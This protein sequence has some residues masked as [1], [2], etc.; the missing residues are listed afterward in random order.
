[1]SIDDALR[2]AFANW[3]AEHWKARLDDVIS[4][5]PG[6]GTRRF[7]R[8]LVSGGDAPASSVIARVDAE[9]DPSK[10]ARGVAP[11]PPLEPIRRLLNEAEIPV[12]RRFAALPEVGA[13]LLEDVGDTTLEGIAIDPATPPERRRALYA[14]AC[15]II[16]RMQ[17]LDEPTPKP[18]P[19]IEAFERTLDAALFESKA[20]RVV[21]WALPYWLPRKPTDR[22]ARIVRDFYQH[23]ARVCEGAPRRLS[24]RDFKAANVHVLPGDRLVLIDLQGAFM[25]P[26]EYDLVC[27]LRDSHV[28]LPWEEVEALL[29]ATRPKLPDA[30][31][32]DVFD[33]RFDLL[34]LTRVAKDAAHY[35]HGYTDSGDERYLPFLPT[36]RTSLREA[37]ERAAE[38]DEEIAPFAALVA[39]LREP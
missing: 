27:L 10:R 17:Q 6:L 20:E 31:A 1:M 18:E 12:P 9:E 37:A 24:H 16:V 3:I 28:A 14:K 22:D 30:P 23:V 15:E 34:T 25:A 21:N 13:E 35:I 4:I 7:Y 2:G 29:E 8:L 38:R 33:A 26:P 36:A 19:P 39:E 32:R 5:A 11:E